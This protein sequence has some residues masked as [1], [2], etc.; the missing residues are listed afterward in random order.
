[1]FSQASPLWNPH[2]KLE[3][4]KVCIRTVAERVQ[5]E[6]KRK[7]LSE[8]DMVNTELQI[9]IN[10]LERGEGNNDLL[11]HVEELRVKKQILIERKGQRL[12]ERLG[13]K[14][15]EEGEKSTRYF[16]RL[17]NRGLPDDFK[18][19]E[20]DNGVVI[21]EE[22]LIEDEIVGFY[23]NLY[24]DFEI[25][26]NNDDASFFDHITAVDDQAANGTSAD[27][28]ATELWSTLQTCSDSA[29]GPDGIPYSYLRCLWT[30][31]GP[32]I[33]EAWNFSLETGNLCQS[34]KL[35][36]LKL[37]PKSGKDLKKLTNWRPI[38]LSNCDHKLITKAY[39]NRL[40]LRM[41][42]SIK[43]RQ[44]AY[45]K[46]R[47]I[48]DN[49]R[50][51][52][53]TIETANLETAIDGLIVSLDA[54]KAFDS[55]DH[56]YIELC[57]KKFGLSSFV[58]IFRI[59]Y[60][61][62]RTDIMI[63]G[64]IVKGFN[65][66]RGVKQGD[67]LSCILFIM[68][69]EPLLCNIENNPNIEPINLVKLNQNLPK[70]YA[71][72]DD[73]NCAIKNKDGTLQ[74]IFAEYCRL[75]RMSGLELNADKTEILGFKSGQLVPEEKLYNV[76]YNGA[77]YV[78]RSK[79][80]IKINGIHFQQN[81]TLM[82][83]TNVG[84]VVRKIDEQMRRWSARRLSLLG[85]IL[86]LKTF[87]IS[88][89]I[90]LLQSIVLTESDF[91]RM[92]SFL[93]RF[94]WNRNYLAAKAPERIKREIMN[95]PVKLGG[96]GMLDVCEMDRGIKL[97]ALGR[98]METKHPFL[99]I[100]KSKLD[101]RNFFY[102]RLAINVDPLTLNAIDLLGTDR[103]SMWELPSHILDANCVKLIKD[104]KLGSC[105]NSV[106]KNSLIYF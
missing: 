10:V 17:L 37:I 21:N 72:A 22:K 43:E 82:R 11:N 20:K 38:T 26:E 81:Q 51:I 95:K 9:A 71:Y 70:A 62:L 102:P 41:V 52:M 106:G 48:N 32:L 31:I 36:F 65:I 75:T 78:L 50:A 33:V 28:T 88:Q 64:R 13:S 55:V 16:L 57:L 97:R 92:N 73:V 98:L 27:L 44:T 94:L 45:I 99:A 34:H 91:K 54:K 23:K 4:A 100:V 87:G 53:A 59:L 19:I 104:V 6:R 83:Q 66:K 85:K 67:A 18:S 93:F 103:R 63:N 5:A 89:I 79:R 25:V 105:I 15:Y 42:D 101:L 7:E 24:E 29:P 12:A 56:N 14:W 76:T 2:V 39:A 47:I 46:G 86:I 69:M 3:F 40:S 49:I 80:S 61:D 68:C 8:E 84:N 96:F 77:D 90:F 74:G 58:K 35:S 1:M 60:K 30:Q